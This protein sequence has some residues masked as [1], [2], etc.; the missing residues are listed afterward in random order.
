M[1]GLAGM[2]DGFGEV[3]RVVVGVGG[4]REDVFGGE[5]SVVIATNTSSDGGVQSS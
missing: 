5:R 4:C 1:E 2:V 3:V